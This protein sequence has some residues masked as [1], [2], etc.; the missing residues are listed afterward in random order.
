MKLSKRILA[1]TACLAVATTMLTATYASADVVETAK[2]LSEAP[3]FRKNGID[4]TADD[5]F[6]CV[7][8][9]PD[10]PTVG[11]SV[12]M[13]QS[14]NF[15]D[16]MYMP[17]VKGDST[18]TYVEG[19]TNNKYTLSYSYSPWAHFY[20]SA[21]QVATT[22]D[23]KKITT[24]KGA[25][26][27]VGVKQP[28]GAPNIYMDA[29][30]NVVDVPD[31]NNIPEGVTQYFQ[32]SELKDAVITGN[33]TFKAAIVNHN[34][35]T[36]MNDTPGI[37]M[38]S[39]TSNIGYFDGKVS[40]KAFTV[41]ASA[42]KSAV[43]EAEAFLPTL[44]TELEELKKA[45]EGGSAEESTEEA[46]EAVTEETTD[47]AAVAAEE[48]TEEV[49]EATGEETT[50]AEATVEEKIAKLEENIAALEAAIASGKEAVANDGKALPSD[51]SLKVDSMTANFY[52]SAESY[53]AGTPD[54]SIPVK[55]FTTRTGYDEASGNSNFTE[56][57][58]IDVYGDSKK[59]S[60]YG[61]GIE[62]VTKDDNGIY[63]AY[64]TGDKSVL[65][66]DG[67]LD[68]I[69]A[70]Q[71]ACTVD[72]PQYAMEVEFTVN[73]A[74]V[75]AAQAA[76]DSSLE[77]VSEAMTNAGGLVWA[78]LDSAIAEAEAINK[79]EYT[80]ASYDKMM[81]AVEAGKAVKAKF[82]NGEEVTQDEIDA[83]TEAIKAAIAALEPIATN[84]SDTPS[85][86][87]IGNSNTPSD[88]GNNNGSGSGNSATDA[89]PGTGAGIAV[90]ASMAVLVA[91]GYVITR[92][93]K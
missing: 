23:G 87:D 62:S 21:A 12:Q 44:Q 80:A 73:N 77:A 85:G 11:I 57:N 61:T 83:A 54:R 68:A 20:V 70:L 24:K 22:L 29:E 8:A 5:V 48:P 67:D 33:G 42:L 1:C 64:F 71:G 6:S 88:G 25:D 55:G 4:L 43:A 49:T 39:L 38:L 90:T 84:P 74:D 10:R 19:D 16:A 63:S 45:A 81:A 58:I 47:E 28:G 31:I 86:G 40:N 15:R 60:E 78:A 79:D 51:Y 92:K 93:R 17:D 91:A 59:M 30:G 76:V 18:G 46:T 37:N 89:N 66:D 41:D 9:L 82:E 14:Y 72:L 65:R 13:G 36:D 52:D 69:G 32:A 35:A 53:E 26:N 27:P 2:P 7:S 50:E 56:Y 3:E 75:F 34:F